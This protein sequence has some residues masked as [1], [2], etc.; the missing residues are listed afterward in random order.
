VGGTAAIEP[1]ILFSPARMVE[2][3]YRL[4]SFPPGSAPQWERFR[5]LFS[6]KAVLALRVFPEDTAVAIMTLE[7]YMVHQMRGGMTEHGYAETIIDSRT[8]IFGDIA[9]A[10]VEFTMT[11]GN[12]APVPALDIFQLARR[13][14]RWWIVCIISDMKRSL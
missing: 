1:E 9:E 11:F 7:E 2:E 6:P 4:I 8:S 12:M 14:N 13:E 10:R 5:E 3:C